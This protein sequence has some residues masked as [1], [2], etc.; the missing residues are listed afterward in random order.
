MNAWRGV[1]RILS[2]DRALVEA[3]LTVVSR[4]PTPPTLYRP[5]AHE[6][7]MHAWQRADLSSASAF[8]HTFHPGDMF[9]LSDSGLAY[10]CP[11]LLAM[12]FLR[13]DGHFQQQFFELLAGR[14]LG[15]VDSM[16]SEA[17]DICHRLS[18][19]IGEVIWSLDPREASI[20]PG[21]AANEDIN[22]EIMRL[23]IA[24]SG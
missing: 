5:E 2:E 7:E 10:F 22:D 19:R 24:F 18:C 11:I 14:D 4:Q 17:K 1:E 15:F 20:Y 9:V 8:A 16:N 23:R 3:A 12:C 21:L 6:G 13:T